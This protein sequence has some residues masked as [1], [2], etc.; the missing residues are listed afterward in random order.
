M[1]VGADVC[2]WQ[3]AVEGAGRPQQTEL[4][5]NVKLL[6]WWVKRGWVELL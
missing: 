2:L 3:E 5:G 6:W 4:C 1:E